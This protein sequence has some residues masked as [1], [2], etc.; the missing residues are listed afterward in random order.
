MLISIS[1]RSYR[2]YAYTEVLK[3]VLIFRSI[4]DL[5][6]EFTELILI[7]WS[8]HLFGGTRRYHKDYGTYT[9]FAELNLVREYP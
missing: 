5:P 7:P 3:H 9:G 2:T 6:Y 4:S 8:L 1:R